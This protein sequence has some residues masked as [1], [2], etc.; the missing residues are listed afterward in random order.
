MTEWTASLNIAALPVK[1]A[2]K[3]LVVATATLPARAA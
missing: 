2:A 3:S 1:A